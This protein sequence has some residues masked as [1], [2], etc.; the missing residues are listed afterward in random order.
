MVEYIGTIARW[1]GVIRKIHI[2]MERMGA[3]GISV[4]GTGSGYSVGVR[5]SDLHGRTLH[6]SFGGIDIAHRVG[7]LSTQKGTLLEQR[8]NA[9][10]DRSMIAEAVSLALHP[11]VPYDEYPKNPIFLTE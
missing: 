2:D 8:E 9:L 4:T 7:R 5:I 1:D 3:H 11:F 10:D 6:E